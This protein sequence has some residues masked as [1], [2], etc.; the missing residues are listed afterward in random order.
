LLG[1]FSKIGKSC[2][3]PIKKISFIT[4][5]IF[6]DKMKNNWFS[7]NKSSRLLTTI[8]TD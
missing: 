7:I 6:I 8:L 5:E 1:N 3:V 2:G 4:A